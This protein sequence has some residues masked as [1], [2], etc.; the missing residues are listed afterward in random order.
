MGEFHIDL[1]GV[2]AI[3]IAAVAL[4]KAWRGAPGDKADAA[5]TY[6]E[7]VACAAEEQ[8]KTRKQ[9]KSMQAQIDCLQ[10]DIDEYKIGVDKLITQ[11]ET[12]NITP[13]WRPKRRRGK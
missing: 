8:E 6:Q 4:V 1:A 13:A 2:A 10:E 12:H 3:V 9:L 11:L 5:R 7:M